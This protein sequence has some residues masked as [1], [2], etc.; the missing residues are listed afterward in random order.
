M[1]ANM[2]TMVDLQ[3]AMACGRAREYAIVQGITLERMALCNCLMRIAIPPLREVS[4]GLRQ[5][6]WPGSRT[7]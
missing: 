6:V 5:A 4:Y 7:T 1:Y 2:S 3:T